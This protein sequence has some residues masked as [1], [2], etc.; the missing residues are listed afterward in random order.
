VSNANE[1]RRW[2]GG[3][4]SAVSCKTSR[5]QTTQKTLWQKRSDEESLNQTFP[6]VD[7]GTLEPEVL[8][9]QDDSTI[10][11]NEGWTTMLSGPDELSFHTTDHNESFFTSANSVAQEMAENQP[12]ILMTTLPSASSLPSD[13]SE[14]MAEHQPS[15]SMTTLPSTSSLP[16]DKSEPNQSLYS[17]EGLTLQLSDTSEEPGLLILT[18]KLE[19]L[20]SAVGAVSTETEI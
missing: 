10:E 14:Q 9:H 13:K 12:S 4:K 20:S 16:N 1:G 7:D 19:I 11:S 3:W 8:I 5:S 18:S 17:L 2:Q 15:I 6:E